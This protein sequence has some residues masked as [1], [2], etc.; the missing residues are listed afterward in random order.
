MTQRKGNTNNPNGRPKGI[1][2]KT[3]Q[4]M[5]SLIQVFVE[6]NIE[7]LQQEYDKLESSEKFRVLERF[8]QYIVPRCSAVEFLD[9]KKEDDKPLV[10]VLTESEEFNMSQFRGND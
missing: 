5:R 9:S 10:I 8:M 2:N 6:K 4:E 1:P 7:G 3:T